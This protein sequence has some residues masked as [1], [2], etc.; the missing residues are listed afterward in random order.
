MS[1]NRA[2][3]N[4]GGQSVCPQCLRVVDFELVNRDN[5]VFM[6]KTCVEHGVF[7][8]LI[9]TDADDYEAAVQANRPGAGAARLQGVVENGC[10]H[11]CGLCPAHRQHSCVGVIEITQ[12]CNLS[13]S[14]CYASSGTGSDVPFERVK[15]MIDLFM[16]C[17]SE[18][19]VLQISGGEPTLHPDFFR[20]LEY[21]GRQGIKYLLINT[22]GI[23]LSDREFTARLAGALNTG[24]SKVKPLIYLQ[25]DGLDDGVYRVLRGR[26]L[27]ETKLAAIENCRQEGL[28]VAL[29]PT[30]VRGINDDKVSEIVDF[31]ISDKA[32]KM[33]NFQPAA[34]TGRYFHGAT[35]RRLT[36]PEIL[37]KIEAGSGGKLTK[38]AFMSV[39][40][41]HPACSSCSYVLNTPEKTVELTHLLRVG[42]LEKRI[43]DRVAP[44]TS[45]TKDVSAVGSALLSM[46]SVMGSAKVETAICKFCGVTIPNIRELIDDI[47]MISVHAF[48]DAYNFDLDRA[49][50]CCITQ[51][52]PD[53]RMIPFCVYNVMYRRQNHGA[54][55]AAAGA[56]AGSKQTHR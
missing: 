29:V 20:V 51:I 19:E 47:T 56:T 52:L 28:N 1:N 36:I 13:C 3:D 44:H 16:F 40:C 37:S 21:A 38:D 18:P 35:D 5:R 34:R 50:K 49:K 39:P 26:P 45:L 6:E 2:S 11:D 15:E 32:I 22:N 53:G 55:E 14:T 8:D 48:M 25:F 23:R 41:P 54:M 31:A 12:A 27:L 4:T 24:R 17:E 10:P 9:S 7:V 30:L 42:G 46:S 33:V 43:N